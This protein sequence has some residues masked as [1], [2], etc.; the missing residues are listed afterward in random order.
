MR[1]ELRFQF[2]QGRFPRIAPIAIQALNFGLYRF[3]VVIIVFLGLTTADFQGPISS[4]AGVAGKQRNRRE[5]GKKRSA[6][7]ALRHGLTGRTVVVPHEDME[8][9][10]RFIMKN[11]SRISLPKTPVE[12]QY[13]QTFCDTLW[14]LNRIRSIENANVF[15]L[16]F[17]P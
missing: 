4:V 6:L 3:L 10:H 7:N 17:A 11:S 9:C 8:A 16:N 2:A 5:E 12:R 1:F 14:R 13:A 15:H